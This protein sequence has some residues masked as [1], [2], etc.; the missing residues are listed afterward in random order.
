MTPSKNG[1]TWAALV[2]A[3]IGALSACQPA[4]P[5]ATA[6][7]QPAPTVSVPPPP[8]PIPFSPSPEPTPEPSNLGAYCADYF[9]PMGASQIPFLT[10]LISMYSADGSPEGARNTAGLLSKEANNVADK[11]KKVATPSIMPESLAGASS[12]LFI[13]LRTLGVTTSDPKI[14]TIRIKALTGSVNRF[15]AACKGI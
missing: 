14:L 13:S 9:A 8:V 1:T 10:N 4:Q 12:E 5:E 2:L 6:Q 7:E 11:M 3:S 15:H